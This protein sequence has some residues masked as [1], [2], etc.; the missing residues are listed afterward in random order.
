MAAPFQSPQRPGGGF[1]PSRRFSLTQQTG[2]LQCAGG[3][4]RVTRPE[5]EDKLDCAAAASAPV[6]MPS[7]VKVRAF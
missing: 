7:G 3:A 4:Q 5:E 1:Q 2:L 6:T